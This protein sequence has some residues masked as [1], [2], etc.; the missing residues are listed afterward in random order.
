MAFSVVCNAA[1]DIIPIAPV[2]NVAG[3]QSILLDG[4]TRLYYQDASGRLVVAGVTAPFTAPGSTTTFPPAEFATAAE[5]LW[6]TPIA[7]CT[8]DN[9][10]SGFYEVCESRGL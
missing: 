2:G 9:G 3:V 5:L 6:G 8:Y 10:T 4:D 7:A 1:T